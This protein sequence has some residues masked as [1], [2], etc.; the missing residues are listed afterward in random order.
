MVSGDLVQVDEVRSGSSYLSQSDLRLF[1]GLGSRQL[2]D[3]IKVM[4]P[5]GLVEVREAIPVN[6]EITLI[7]AEK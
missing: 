4:W 3:R 2:V 5:S 1:F 7:E 6:G